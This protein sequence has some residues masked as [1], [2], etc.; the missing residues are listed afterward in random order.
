MNDTSF[1]DC[2][3]TLEEQKSFFFNIL[4]FWAAAFVS[5]LVYGYHD[6]LVLFSPFS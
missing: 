2:E 3:K 5:L 6:F 4:Y 1:E